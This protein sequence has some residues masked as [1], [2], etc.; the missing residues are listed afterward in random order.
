MAN[1]YYKQGE[2]WTEVPLQNNPYGI[3]AYYKSEQ[4]I[5]PSTIVGGTWEY[6]G[7]LDWGEKPVEFKVRYSFHFGTTPPDKFFYR[8]YGHVTS[9]IAGYTRKTDLQND[10]TTISGMPAPILQPS[11][12]ESNVGVVVGTVRSC[13]SQNRNSQW[14]TYVPDG[15]YEYYYTYL[16]NGTGGGY[17][18]SF[19]IIDKNGN[20]PSSL[21]WPTSNTRYVIQ[22]DY[23]TADPLDE[24][25][26]GGVYVWKRTA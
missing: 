19:Y 4:K 13:I 10:S 26:E 6:L 11:Y 9:Y 18:N 5:S 24:S 22:F 1:L 17:H 25:L 12:G 23:D 21:D 7:Y 14:C 3:G 16:D 20:F 2:D 15:E 8:H